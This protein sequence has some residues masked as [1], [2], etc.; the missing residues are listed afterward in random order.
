MQ[1]EHQQRIRNLFQV[2]WYENRG[3]NLVGI[4][5]ILFEGCAR[6][7]RR[8]SLAFEILRHICELHTP[9]WLLRGAEL[10]QTL[11]ILGAPKSV[12]KGIID[13]FW[14]SSICDL[15]GGLGN[16]WYREG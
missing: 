13:S 8:S 11:C 14:V 16:V 4:P 9:K 12:K 3:P 5:L 7:W 10:R 1:I 6:E 15:D 2:L